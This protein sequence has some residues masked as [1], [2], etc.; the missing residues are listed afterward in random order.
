MRPRPVLVLVIHELEQVCRHAHPARADACAL[1]DARVL[2]RAGDHVHV[3]GEPGR[4]FFRGGF[5]RSF[6]CA[7]V[8]L[9]RL[10]HY[11]GQRKALRYGLRRGHLAGWRK[12]TAVKSAALVVRQRES[13]GRPQARLG[14]KL[15]G[16]LFAGIRDQRTVEPLRY[17]HGR[18]AFI[19]LKS[20][21]GVVA[22][23]ALHRQ[24]HDHVR[25]VVRE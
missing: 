3:T 8:V 18:L 12:V 6:P 21:K 5:N 13:L 4:V 25:R 16:A 11:V 15:V 14:V 17:V 24:G 10:R 20:G 9:G 1:D 23:R 7:V 22:Q 19:R 2:H